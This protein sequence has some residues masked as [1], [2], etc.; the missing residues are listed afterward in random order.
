MRRLFSFALLLCST[1]ISADRIATTE[2]GKRVLL[3]ENGTWRY[4][5]G[6][7]S[8]QG[9]AAKR[10]SL[11][12]IVRNDREFDFRKVRWGMSGKEVLASEESTPVKNEPSEIEYKVQF[13]GYDCVVTYS[14]VN[15]A[16]T[17]A[18]FLI[19]QPHVDPALY[20]KDYED[21]KRYLAPLYGIAV[22]DK[23][24]WKNE[25]YRDDRSKWGFAV[26]LG[27]LACGTQWR[28][29]RTQITLAI[30]GGNHQIATNLDYAAWGKR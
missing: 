29:N 9:T 13:L 1:I 4:L 28:S 11:I 20:Y 8:P 23:C 18:G 12:E 24:D 30:S 2:D 3:L 17:R 19:R 21:L 5:K 14:L 22:S 16:L 15:D 6:N 10:I 7:E 27:F 25:M 26:S